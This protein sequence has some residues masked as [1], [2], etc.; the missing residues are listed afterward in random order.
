MQLRTN[1]DARLLDAFVDRSDPE[2]F[3]ALVARH[4]P[5]VLRVCRTVLRDDH[6]AEDAFQATF[7]TLFKKAGA[8]QDPE[9]LKGWLCGVAYKTAARIRQRS[10]RLSEREQ[11]WDEN[12]SG[13]EVVAESDHDLFLIV[14]E[15]LERLPDRYRAPLVLCYLEGLTHEQAASHLGW[16][17]GTVKVRLV[18]G[19]KLLRERLDRRKI[20]LA[21]G[22]LL[23]W[24]REAGAA[25]PDGLVESTL[26]AVIEDAPLGLSHAEAAAL[27]KPALFSFRFSI[28]D[29]AVICGAVVLALFLGSTAATSAAAMI[30]W[31]PAAATDGADLPSNLTDVLAIDCS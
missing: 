23:L 26:G 9:S 1:N 13:C 27:S 5:V 10:I 4:G 14:R 28:G 24:R 31:G 19:R 25:P 16:A 15:E 8:I 2:A 6:L 22:L 29:W 21:A 11:A 20:T 3:A 30:P 12:A 17:S 18:R 7:L